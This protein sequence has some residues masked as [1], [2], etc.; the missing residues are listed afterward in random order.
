MARRWSTR[1]LDRVAVALT[2]AGIITALIIASGLTLGQRNADG[3]LVAK[4]SSD[5]SPIEV[6]SFDDRRVEKFTE[7]ERND[8]TGSMRFAVP[9]PGA[10]ALLGLALAGLGIL[11]RRIWLARRRDVWFVNSF[12]ARLEKA[13]LGKVE[14]EDE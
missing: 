12:P 9:R 7:S 6:P 4:A 1:P 5:T 11:S 3:S 14:S 8:A 13:S 10:I 2:L